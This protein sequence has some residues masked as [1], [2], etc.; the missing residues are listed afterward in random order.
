MDVTPPKPPS[1]LYVITKSNWGGAQRYV[2]ELA[3]EAHRRGYL[4]SVAVGAPGELVE[5]LHEAGIATHLIPGLSRDV[6]LGADLRALVGL[7]ALIHRRRPAIVH[8]NSSKAGF[9]AVLAARAMRVPHIIFTAHGWAWNELRPAWQQRA[10]KLLHL[11]TVLLSHTTIAVSHA[12]FKDASWMPV[13][14]R[15][16]V[17]IHHGVSPLPL[18]PR[19]EARRAMSEAVATPIP[20]N[21]LWVGA[22]A[23][24]HPTKGLDVLIRAFSL[25]EGS[26]AQAVL[27]LV[28]AGQDKGRLTAL[29]HMLR[30]EDRVFFAG[31]IRDA[32]RLLPALDL[33]VLP[34]HSEALGY[35]L[36]EAGQ[37]KL[38]VVA[39]DV[40]G[41]PEIV[42]DGVTGVLVSAGDDRELSH[43][44][45]SMMEH[46]EKRAQYA[47]N[48]YDRVLSDFS[49]EQMFAK[50]FAVYEGS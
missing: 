38:P 22:V 42:E 37:A 46:D 3:V 11:A 2:Y 41:I 48:L 28:G 20:A 26:L 4:V 35:A 45:V 18:V 21:A 47:Q 25:A 24:L 36:L 30:I 23:E 50:T 17:V 1:I 9:I 14:R 10:F 43:A 33:F 34:S 12:I 15:R 27:V 31:H 49:T 16:W 40:G 13:P 6:R 39:S 8:A 19:A 5:R 32:A 7:A 44:L 29:A